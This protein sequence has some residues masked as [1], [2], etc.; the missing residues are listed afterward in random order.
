MEAYTGEIR[1]VLSSSGRGFLHHSNLGAF[2]GKDGTFDVE[3][4]NAR[5]E[6]MSADA[7]AAFCEAAG[8]ALVTQEIVNWGCRD[9]ID[10]ISCVSRAPAA[11]S[12]AP[13]RV[14]N[15][16][17]MQAAGQAAALADLYRLADGAAMPS[18][19]R[20][21]SERPALRMPRRSGTASHSQENRVSGSSL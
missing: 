9:L 15:P 14:E 13:R 7:F 5:G 10:C 8:L 12:A 17:F 18:P 11:E 20:R 3:Q 16:G 21:A 1:R 4:R 6:T 19:L 2:R